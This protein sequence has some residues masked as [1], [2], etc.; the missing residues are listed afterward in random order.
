MKPSL[1]FYVYFSYY[2]YVKYIHHTYENVL[3]KTDVT[4]DMENF[5]DFV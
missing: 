2:D 3:P 5:I 1:S 4:L